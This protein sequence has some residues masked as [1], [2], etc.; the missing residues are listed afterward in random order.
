[1]SAAR[2]LE[3]VYAPGELETELVDHAVSGDPARVNLNKSFGQFFEKTGKGY[4]VGT[5]GH[6]LSAVQTEHW[7]GY[8]REGAPPAEQVIP[9]DAKHVGTINVSQ[10]E[11]AYEF[12]RKWDARLRIEP[13]AVFVAADFQRGQGRAKRKVRVLDNVRVDWFQLEQLKVPIGMC[14]SYLLDAVAFVGVPEVHVFGDGAL[15][16]YAF[17]ASSKPIVEAARIA[18]VMTMRV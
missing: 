15:A 7:H 10:L 4:I 17:T 6:R 2:K 14:L 9:W 11:G 5:D 18:V 3:K 8:K 1:M 16:P 13:K 12:P